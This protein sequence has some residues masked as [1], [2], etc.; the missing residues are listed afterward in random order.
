[1]QGHQYIHEIASRLVLYIGVEGLRVVMVERAAAAC[2]KLC[3]SRISESM[4]LHI[5]LDEL[6]S[7]FPADQLRFPAAFTNPLICTLRCF[8]WGDPRLCWGSFPHHSAS[9]L[10]FSGSNG[11]GREGHWRPRWWIRFQGTINV[12]W[13][14]CHGSPSC[15]RSDP[16]AGLASCPMF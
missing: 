9:L 7:I 12:A 6:G 2:E 15:L 3:L 1:M 14:T 4:K 13:W 16:C 10:L 5:S 11:N 8:F